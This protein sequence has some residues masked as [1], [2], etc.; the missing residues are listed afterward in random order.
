[1]PPEWGENT[2]LLVEAVYEEQMSPEEVE[3]SYAELERLCAAG[4][5]EDDAR[6]DA[7]LVEMDRVEKAR[8]RREWGLSE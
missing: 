7:A 6:L 3:Q 8:M 2:E 4:D 5:P 1:L